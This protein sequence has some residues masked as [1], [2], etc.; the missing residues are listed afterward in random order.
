[1]EVAMS[2]EAELQKL[3]DYPATASQQFR[4]QIE[5]IDQALRRLG[6]GDTAPSTG[7]VGIDRSSEFMPIE[8]PAV[9]T[10]T[11]QD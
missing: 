9:H 4:D 7:A 1:M 5:R 6:Y 10:R 2:V 11:L 8:R 3:R